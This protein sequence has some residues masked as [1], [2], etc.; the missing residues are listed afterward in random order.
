MSSDAGRPFGRET[1]RIRGRGGLVALD[2]A[3]IALVI[4]LGTSGP[5]V[6]VGAAATDTATPPAPASDGHVVVTPKM[7]KPREAQA[8]SAAF[9]ATAKAVRPSVVR[10][11]VELG[12]P[13]AEGFGRRRG[14]GGGEGPSDDELRH[15]FEHFFGGQGPEG[16]D[17]GPPTPGR[18]TGSGVIIDA[19][20]DVVTNGH[21]VERASKVT[22]VL[23]DGQEIPAK[24]VGRDPRTDVAVVRMQKVPSNLVVARLGDPDKLEVGEWVLAIGSPLGLDQTVTAGIISGKGHVGRRVQMSG[25]RVRGYISTDAKINPGNSGGPLVNLDGEV[26]GIN[27]LINTGPGGAYGFAIP[28]NEVRRVTDALLKEGRVRYAYLGVMLGDLTALTPADKQKLG[29]S[30]PANGAFVSTVSPNGPAA[31]AGLHPGDVITKI[32]NQKIETPGDVIDYISSKSIGSKVTVGF[33]RDGK[34]GSTQATLGELPSGQGETPEIAE[35]ATIGVA[36]QTLTP[37]IASS[38]GLPPTTKGVVVADVVQGS[39]AQAA[40]L[41]P[42]D[43]LLE[44]DRKAVATADE[45]TELL[46]GGPKGPG[47]A[48]L[49]RV[50]GPKGPHFVTIP[51]ATP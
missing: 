6:S 14:P 1:F 43:V 19:K 48:H 20:G 15:F 51:A 46:G 21:V 4:V 17:T 18:G 40:G 7:E 50:A 12:T 41:Q 8:L 42:G 25:E 5:G 30:P 11:D 16:P 13:R 26:V 10:I 24:V 27:T 34:P 9:A 49:L 35:V 38:L 39:R 36:L 31:A 2:L 33:V 29:K 37:E 22:V 23:D 28:I 44:V 3:L 32:D 45:A 47:G